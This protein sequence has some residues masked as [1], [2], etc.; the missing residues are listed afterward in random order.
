[1]T[2]ALWIESKSAQLHQ[3]T[4]VSEANRRVVLEQLDPLNILPDPW[5]GQF[6]FVDRKTANEPSLSVVNPTGTKSQKK[7]LSNDLSWCPHTFSTD[8][9]HLLVLGYGANDQPMGLAVFSIETSNA[10]KLINEIRLGAN[11]MLYSPQFCEAHVGGFIGEPGQ[12]LNSYHEWDYLS[13]VRRDSSRE[14]ILQ[15]SL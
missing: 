6:V 12:A 4:L 10:F 11:Q 3:L 2:E 5:R 13:Q 9:K 15:L 14:D 8:G 7:K 1:M